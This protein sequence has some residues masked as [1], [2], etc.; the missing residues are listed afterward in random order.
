MKPTKYIALLRGINIGGH[1]V[2]MERLRAL[3][4]E[5]GFSNVRTYIQ[6]GNVFFESAETDAAELTGKI[7]DHLRAALGYDVPTFVRTIE[8]LAETLAAAPFDGIELTPETRHLIV[9]IS[10]S[11]P[12]DLKLPLLSPKG[13]YE[14]I[15]LTDRA[16]FVA[17]HLIKGKFASSNFLEQTFGVKTTARFYHTAGKILAAARSE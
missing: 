17:V 16:V 15:G 8:Q 13:D 9:F 3:F 14:L 1:N 12:A 2:Q 5:L 11:L 6:T 4:V 7:E 10:K